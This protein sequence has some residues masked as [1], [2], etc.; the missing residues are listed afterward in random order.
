MKKTP[1]SANKREITTVEVEAALHAAL[2]DEGHLFPCTEEDVAEL[3]ASLDLKG[4]P[5]PDTNKFRQV[6]A[7]KQQ[8]KIVQFPQAHQAESAMAEE[9]L[10]IAARNGGKITDATRKK[11][12]AARARSEKRQ[13]K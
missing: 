3:E 2:R 7:E 11:M 9:N 10:A 8:Y 4:V 5:T 12:D 6:L 1:N 13:S